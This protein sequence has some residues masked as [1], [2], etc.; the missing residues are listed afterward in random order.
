MFQDVVNM[1]KH[2]GGRQS[3]LTVIISCENIYGCSVLSM[4][5]VY[6]CC[7]NQDQMGKQSF[8]TKAHLFGL[9]DISWCKYL[10][11]FKNKTLFEPALLQVALVNI[12]TPVKNSCASCCLIA[13]LISSKRMQ[14]QLWMDS[15]A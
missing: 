1:N 6:L 9:D 12:Q 15:L 14:W 2:D 8:H 13:K 11:I 7:F 10:V 3:D 4:V 5:L